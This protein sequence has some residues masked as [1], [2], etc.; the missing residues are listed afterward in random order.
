MN[1]G[2]KLGSPDLQYETAIKQLWQKN[3]FQYIE[4]LAIPNSFQSTIHFWKQFEIPFVIHAP[5]AKHGMNA[6][7]KEL[8]AENIEKIKETFEFA[9]ALNAE[10]IIFHPGTLG[11]IN[12]TVRQF[13]PFTDPRFLIENKPGI[14]F[15][16][17]PCLGIEPEE[18]EFLME[19]LGIGFCFDFGHAVCAANLLKREPFKLIEGFLKLKPQ[20]Y[21]LT[22]G[23]F[24]NEMD[25]HLHYGDGDFPIG[26]FL[27]MIPQNAK[28]TNEAKHDSSENLDD[29][30]AD[31]E[32]LADL[33]STSQKIHV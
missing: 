21:H 24:T 20:M 6:S 9:N 11:D 5:H 33:T 23:F 4:L 30:L 18:I 31:A 16:G 29:F 15:N 13:L 10:H 19:K 32:T 3:A 27:K 2:L 28:I 8:E 7:I 25:V 12:E 1:L 17:N 22:D 14:A 26:E